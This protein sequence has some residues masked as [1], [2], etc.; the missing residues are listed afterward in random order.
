MASERLGDIIAR[1]RNIYMSGSAAEITQTRGL[2]RQY[3]KTKSTSTGATVTGL[4][5]PIVNQRSYADPDIGV[6]VR[7]FFLNR[8]LKR[9]LALGHVHYCPWRYSVI[10]R[11]MK[12]SGRFDTAIVMLSPPD[13]RGMCSMGV[14]VDF[15]PSFLN[16][17]EHIVGFINPNMPR[18]R[19][20][21]DV[22]YAALAATIDSDTPLLTMV[23][24]SSDAA[25]ATIARHIVALIADGSTVQVGIGQ[26]PS[27]V[28]A[29]L[30]HHRRLRIHTGVVD[31][32][33]LALD[34]SGALDRDHPI[35]TGTA[36]GSATLYAHM[37]CNDRYAFR[38]VAHTHTHRVISAIENFVAI[39]SVLQVDLLGQTSAE[40][41]GGQL[42]SS[43]G[44]LPDFV[45]GALDGV[46]G[47]SIIA[48]RAAGQA[49]R[50]RG[51]VPLLQSPH[52]V[53]TTLSDAD[54]FVSEFGVAKVRD[55]PLDQRAEA[56]IAIAAP[57]DRAPL[58][59]QWSSI[60]SRLAPRPA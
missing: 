24:K 52:A 20:D 1:S 17:A 40:A 38:A 30:R 50:I 22:P 36:V 55:L 16:R 39:N 3:R 49:G 33:I 21:G 5:S 34:D 35:V 12:Q 9:D 60:R 47:R 23:E 53:T 7:S 11:W 31:D 45:R 28:I 37:D 42:V 51:I 27:Q 59:D 13:A 43:P 26:I 8:E 44:G 29:Q 54:V 18:T 41:S 57:Q 46:G 4:F 19:G 32:N 15:L 14:Q 25:V 2:M 58:L 6:M 56:L 10:D 48:V